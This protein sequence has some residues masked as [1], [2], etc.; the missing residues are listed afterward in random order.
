MKRN[1]HPCHARPCERH[2]VTGLEITDMVLSALGDLISALS[3]LIALLALHQSQAPQAV[4]PARLHA[5][6]CSDGRAP[7]QCQVMEVQRPSP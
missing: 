6:V 2:P 5:I 7:E 3:V 1:Y 4:A